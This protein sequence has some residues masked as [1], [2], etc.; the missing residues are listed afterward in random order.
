MNF[1]G[2]RTQLFPSA[3]VTEGTE[4]VYTCPAG[5]KFF[6]IESLLV[7]DVGA[8]GKA[9]VVLRDAEDVHIRHLNWMLIRENNKGV[10]PSDHC[11]P[12]YPIELTAGMNVAVV[13][14]AASLEAQCDMF[15]METDA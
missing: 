5:K 13:S 8:A 1:H 4:V 3:K 15:G 12:A 10:I 14:D 7:S 11:E 9:E 2:P 6:M